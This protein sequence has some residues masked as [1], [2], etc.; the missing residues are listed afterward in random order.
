MADTAR[1]DG[2][3]SGHVRN[4]GV[5]EILEFTFDFQ[6]DGAQFGGEFG[7]QC[8]HG[9]VGFAD[10]MVDGFRPHLNLIKAGAVVEIRT[11]DEVQLFKR[12][13]TTIDGHQVTR[14]ITE[15]LVDLLD[16][17]RMRLIQKS[18]ENGNAGLGD[19]KAGGAQ[20]G[21]GVFKRLI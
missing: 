4:I 6:D 21:A 17:D 11:T 8:G 13:Q 12:S 20:A 15:G 3:E 16:G 2:E 14:T 19:A 7:R 10:D 9:I 5:A 1:G 18:G